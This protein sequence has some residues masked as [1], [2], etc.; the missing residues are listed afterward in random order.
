[1]VDRGVTLTLS[2]PTDLTNKISA[3]K[4]YREFTGAGLKEAKEAIESIR[5]GKYTSVFP[6]Y[7]ILKPQFD[8]IVDKFKM[9]GLSVVVV[10]ENNPVRDA[11]GEE[12]H[13]LVTYATLGAQYDLAKA[14]LDI[15]ETFCVKADP[16][17][18]IKKALETKDEE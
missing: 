6:T 9:A 13:R 8:D 11:I 15:A 16:N 4:T 14:L 5:P 3:I 10:Q 1:M 17:F 12:I 7:N 18:D 2:H